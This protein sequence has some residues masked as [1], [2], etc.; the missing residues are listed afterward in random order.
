MAKFMQQG[1]NKIDLGAGVAIQAEVERRA[2]EAALVAEVDVELGLDVDVAVAG[3]IVGLAGA[4]VGA[5]KFVGQRL[6][7]PGAWCPPGKS[8]QMFHA[9]ALPSTAVV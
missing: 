6:R 4:Q 5:G 7:V 9:P 2:V 3:A 1:F 8:R